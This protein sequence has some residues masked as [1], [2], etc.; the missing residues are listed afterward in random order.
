MK[1]LNLKFQIKEI[2][3]PVIIIT[4]IL[5]A[6]TIV[7]ARERFFQVQSIDTMKFSR[8]V[9]RE[10]LKDLSYDQ[11]IEVQ[12]KIISQTGATHVA[13]ATPYDEE[14]LPFLKRWVS[15]AR[16]YNLKVWFRGNLSGWENWFEYPQIDRN[17]HTDNIQRFILEHPDLFEDGDI[18]TSCPECENGGP[19]DPRMNGDAQGFKNFLINEYQVVKDSFRNIGK[20][21]TANYYSMNGDVARLIMDK[22][23]TSALDGV[24]TV[25]HYVS[26]PEKLQADIREYVSSSGGKIVLGE[27]GAPIPDIHGE[28]TESDQAKWIEKALI[29]ILQT[30]EVIGINYWTNKGSSTELWTENNSAKSAVA[31]LSKYFDPVNITGTIKDETGQ[32]LKEVTVKGKEKTIVVTDGNY[33]LPVL[34]G[35]SVTFSKYGYVSRNIKV[36]AEK[37]K[38]VQRDIVLSRSYPS[39]IITFFMKI[40][41]FFKSLLK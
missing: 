36:D 29:K 4:V 32:P 40:V 20:N 33:T 28:M 30:S 19:G 13:I 3:A 16:K 2:V 9:A 8:D 31:T 22:D 17:K 34:D 26:T 12:V 6:P 7:F 25:D 10:K 41:D 35:E 15:A 1:I 21:V 38:D 23:T 14:F 24:I 39:P 11:E 27:F 5:L 18:F 37:T